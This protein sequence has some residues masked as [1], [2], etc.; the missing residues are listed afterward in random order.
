MR[1]L[2]SLCPMRVLLLVLVLTATGCAPRVGGSPVSP[3]T[4][5]EPVSVPGVPASAAEASAVLNGTVTTRARIALP[6]SATVRVRI[7]DVSLADA[8]ARV[9][10]EQTIRPTTQV[11]I[12][13][14][15]AYDAGTIDVRHRYAVRAEIRDAAGVLRWTTTTHTPVFTQ[16]GPVDGVEVVVEQIVD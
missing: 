1:G 2:L 5:T 11:P 8:P 4:S 13:F 15:L 14:A 10:S 3:N 6:D 12:P 16:G 7:E 9:V